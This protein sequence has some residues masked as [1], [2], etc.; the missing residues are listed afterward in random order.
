MKVLTVILAILVVAL[1]VSP[2]C[3]T[4]NCSD[5]EVK[6][7]GTDNHAKDVDVCSPFYSC[8][9][10]IGFTVSSHSFEPVTVALLL[11]NYNLADYQQRFFSQFHH[12]IWQPPKV[13]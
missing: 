11:D 7:E 1:S 9:A 8:S 10:C 5:D 13:G 3:L 4:E 12:A 6:T 2:C